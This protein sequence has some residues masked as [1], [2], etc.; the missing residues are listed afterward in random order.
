MR[1]LVECRCEVVLVAFKVIRRREPYQV[2]VRDIVGS[3]AAV[4]D[5]RLGRVDE[6]Q[7]ILV[8]VLQDFRLGVLGRPSICASLKT[9]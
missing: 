4:I 6:R 1:Q 3:V 5:A 8:G 7:R 2:H 9:V